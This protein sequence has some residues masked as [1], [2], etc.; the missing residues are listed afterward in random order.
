MDLGH[1]H[2]AQ[3]RV[4]TREN[5]ASRHGVVKVNAGEEETGTGLL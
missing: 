4:L 3:Y 1:A 5:L 2:A